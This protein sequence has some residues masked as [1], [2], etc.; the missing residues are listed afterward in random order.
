[1]KDPEFIALR[2]KWLFAFFIALIFIVPLFI[3]IF[4]TYD[5]SESDILKMIKKG[6]SFSLLILDNSCDKC[7][8]VNNIMKKNNINYFILNKSKDK[9]YEEIMIRLTLSNKKIELPVVV[10]V[11]DGE[12]KSYL[13][14]V[15]DE[16][17]IVTFLSNYSN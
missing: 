4:K 16:K 10:Y 9:H 5:T 11:E 12:M 7:E 6:E 15:S 14:D 2:N 3:F 17:E 1:M 13:V 8:K